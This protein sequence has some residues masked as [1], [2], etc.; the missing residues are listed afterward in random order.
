MKFRSLNS[1]SVWQCAVSR[2]KKLIA[3]RSFWRRSSSNIKGIISHS[4]LV[5]PSLQSC[6]QVSAEWRSAGE[7]VGG[8]ARSRRA[9]RALKRSHGIVVVLLAA[10]KP[11]EGYQ[12]QLR[13]GLELSDQ[14]SQC[15]AGRTRPDCLESLACL[16]RP[17][18]RAP[19]D[20]LAEV[21]GVEPRGLFCL[22]ALGRR[23]DCFDHLARKGLKR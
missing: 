20:V 6:T 1:F 11:G 21:D 17:D 18:D 15:C 19:V 4:R 12:L 7:I 23:G 3:L 22:P 16:L 14:P 13:R 5:A 10:A 2:T 8:I 9:V